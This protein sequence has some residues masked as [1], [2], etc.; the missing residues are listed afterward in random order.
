MT[1]SKPT[2]TVFS[3]I[4]RNKKLSLYITNNLFWSQV[5]LKRRWKS[6]PSLVVFFLCQREPIMPF[7]LCWRNASFFFMRWNDLWPYFVVTLKW[8]L[9]IT[10]FSKS[11]LLDGNTF[12]WDF[13]EN[14]ENE[15]SLIYVTNAWNLGFRVSKKGYFQKKPRNWEC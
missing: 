2:T 3:D 6:W 12:T 8:S 10:V 14:K 7:V 5:F 15:L 9:M 13:T 1:K 11:V 4:Y